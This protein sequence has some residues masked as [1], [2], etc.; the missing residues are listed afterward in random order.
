METS[1]TFAPVKHQQLN[2]Q[3][4][5]NTTVNEITKDE[6]MVI[7]S[8]CHSNLKS[9]QWIISPLKQEIA[10]YCHDKEERLRMIDRFDN[11]ARRLIDW[12]GE[13]VVLHWN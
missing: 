11:I 13:S 1:C 7:I 6:A 12:T 9:H 8:A 3:K 2:P 4:I 10:V 5:M